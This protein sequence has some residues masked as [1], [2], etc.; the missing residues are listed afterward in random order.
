MNLEQLSKPT[1]IQIIEDLERG[2]NEEFW[3]AE[4]GCLRQSN[5]AKD[6]TITSLHKQLQESAKLGAS[7]KRAIRE[8]KESNMANR[9]ADEAVFIGN[10][11][12]LWNYLLDKPEPQQ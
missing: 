10:D 1:L 6:E 4:N 12:R 11:R 2:G 8:H 5:E 3:Q 9:G 7:F